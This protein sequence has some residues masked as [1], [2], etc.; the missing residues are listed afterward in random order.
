MATINIK[1]YL[2]ISAVTAILLSP[3]TAALAQTSSV[4]VPAFNS[5]QASQAKIDVYPSFVQS[6]HILTTKD[7]KQPAYEMFIR[8]GYKLDGK[9]GA[10]ADP[11]IAKMQVETDIPG[12]KFFGIFQLVDNAPFSIIKEMTTG[13]YWLHGVVDGIYKASVCAD[14]DITTGLVSGCKQAEPRVTQDSVAAAA[15]LARSLGE[16]MVKTAS[17]MKAFTPPPV[18]KPNETLTTLNNQRANLMQLKK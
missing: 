14:Y 9:G 17:D 18:A 15:D 1:Q 6:S 16:Q 10:V 8:A 3:A 7:T 4:G 5:L 13:E 12:H 11:A 2:L